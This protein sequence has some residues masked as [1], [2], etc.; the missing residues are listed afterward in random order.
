MTTDR[1][2]ENGNDM[3]GRG[4]DPWRLQFH[5]MPPDGWLNDPNGL[6]QFRGEYHVFF[7]YSPGQPEGGM[8]HWGHYISPDLLHW[9]YAGIALSPEKEY[10]SRGA[11]SGSALIRDGKM[12]LFYTGNVKLTGNYDYITNGRQGNTIHVS[13]EDGRTFGEKTLLLTNDDYPDNLTCHVRDPKVMPGEEI[14]ISDGCDYMLL[15]ARTMEDEGEI[16]LYRSQDLRQWELASIICSEEKL[17]YMWE[18]PDAFML[19]DQKILSISPQGVER[20]GINYANIYQSGYFLVD[21]AFDGICS[22]RDFKEWDRGFDFYAPQTFSDEHGRRILIGWVG[23]ADDPSQW[24]PTV[25]HGWQNALTVPREVMLRDGKVCQYPVE[26]LKSLR[27]ETHTLRAGERSEKM[28]CYDAELCLNA[29]S[30]DFEMSISDGIGL[31]YKKKEKIFSLE[32]D[33]EKNFGCGRTV[34]SVRLEECRRIR[35]LMDTSC[36]EVY[37]NDG[38]EV[39]TSRF[40]TE[41]GES[42]FEVKHGTAEI[43]YWEIVPAK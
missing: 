24:N 6:C 40:Y 16:L 43:R 11:Y 2:P 18:C 37:L 10:E 7:Q 30:V 25:E 13:S 3:A 39:F 32:F 21:G 38:E 22:L 14:G 36:I 33:R 35:L 34:R 1:I 8:K 17:G 41:D 27:G 29:D 5:L 42:W 23:M 20:D 15:G 19:G 12:H 31:S 9:E 4:K 28:A 26:E